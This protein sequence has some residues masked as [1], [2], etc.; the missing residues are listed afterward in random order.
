M[1]PPIPSPFAENYSVQIEG[2]LTKIAFGEVAETGAV[3]YHTGIV[4]S[5]SNAKGLADLVLKLLAEVSGP[6]AA[7]HKPN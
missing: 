6:E 5:T 3:V 1:K 7:K 2:P 4:L